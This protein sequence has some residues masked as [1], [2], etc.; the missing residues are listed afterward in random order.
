MEDTSDCSLARLPIEGDLVV[1]K[2]PIRRGY[3]Y[4]E[5]GFPWEPQPESLAQIPDVQERRELTQ[6]MTALL[7]AS[8]SA[9]LIVLRGNCYRMCPNQGHIHQSNEFRFFGLITKLGIPK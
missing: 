9:V 3:P 8:Y 7:E 5:R 1:L 2:E 4:C 6:R